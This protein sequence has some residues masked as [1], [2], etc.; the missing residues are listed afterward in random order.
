MSSNDGNLKFWKKALAVFVPYNS[1]RRVFLK[2]VLQLL[3]HPRQLV[4][5]F[6]LQKLKRVLYYL[7]FW[8]K[9]CL[10]ELI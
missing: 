1:R 4:Y 2:M 10:W 7:R 3:N 8:M 6:R 9:G 5:Y